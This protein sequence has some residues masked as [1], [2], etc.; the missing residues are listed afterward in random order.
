M[1][2][3]MELSKVKK[4]SLYKISTLITLT[5]ICIYFFYDL[6]FSQKLD[7][8]P[9][10]E[11]FPTK[12]EFIISN[13]KTKMKLE[14]AEYTIREYM[15]TADYIQKELRKKDKD[16]DAADILTGNKV[17]FNYKSNGSTGGQNIISVSANYNKNTA[18]D[19]IIAFISISTPTFNENTQQIQFNGESIFSSLEIP[20]SSLKKSS[21]ITDFIKKDGNGINQEIF[22][23]LIENTDYS[24]KI[25]TKIIEKINP[26][27]LEALKNSNVDISKRKDQINLELEHTLVSLATN[28]NIYYFD[29]AK[30][31]SVAFLF[32]TVI[33]ILMRLITIEV[34][35][36]NDCSKMLLNH[37]Y[38]EK[39]S[40]NIDEHIK[41][42]S[43]IVGHSQN[44]EDS[45]KHDTISILSDLVSLIK[46]KPDR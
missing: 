19:F 2:Y 10:D 22:F 31:T 3:D 32:I 33:A 36:I 25:I 9:I 29:M 6:V 21:S 38:V 37:I 16:R 8:A 5:F 17:V 34:K 15:K 35:F 46:G 40:K 23:K 24:E 30:R 45:S 44:T 41:Y 11:F 28:G 1:Q 4:E 39:S 12:K 27:F 43:F 7:V 26:P 13:I 20:A 18:G 42:S 14:D